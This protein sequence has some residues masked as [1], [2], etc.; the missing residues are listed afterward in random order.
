MAKLL[1]LDI[2]LDPNTPEDHQEACLLSSLPFHW[3]RLFWKNGICQ[4][5]I[6]NWRI[7]PSTDRTKSITC[8]C[9]GKCSVM[10]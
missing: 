2:T 4:T 7:R 10:F 3:G 8:G 9:S 5:D 1:A 6:W